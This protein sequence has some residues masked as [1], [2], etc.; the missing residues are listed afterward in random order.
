MDN[1]KIIFGFTGL[2]SSGKGGAGEYLKSKYN[3]SV[4][5]FSKSI[6]DV[7]DRIL[8]II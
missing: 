7:L 2:M 1:A 8:E 3:A 5:S 6:C 4:F